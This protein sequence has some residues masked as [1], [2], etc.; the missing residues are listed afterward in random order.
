MSLS[1]HI[2]TDNLDPTKRN[3]ALLFVG[4]TQ[5]AY[6]VI[7]GGAAFDVT[8]QA[9]EQARAISPATHIIVRKLE[10][11]GIWVKL[12]PE[13]WFNDRVAPYLAWCQKNEVVYLTDNESSGDDDTIRR[14]AAWQADVMARLH[15]VGLRAAVCAFS[16]GNI[17]ENQYALLKPVYDAMIPGDV[18]A[19]HEYQ[20]A[21]HKSS[22][23]HVNRYQLAWQA[24]GR[25]LPTVITEAGIAVDYNPGLGYHSLGMSAADYVKYMAGFDKDWYAPHNVTIC[26]Y[27]T[28]GYG[29][30]SFQISDDV[31]T[32]LEKL[33]AS[34]PVPTP[35][36]PPPPPSGDFDYGEMRPAHIRI[37]NPTITTINMRREPNIV[38][39]IWQ[40]V[41]SGDA[42]DWSLTER[43]IGGYNWHKVL[44]KTSG[45][46]G[47][48]AA[49]SSFEV[50][51][52]APPQPPSP[53]YTKI[54]ISK[55]N[56]AQ[57][58]IAEALTLLR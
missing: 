51:F 24:A 5:P 20:N 6:A 32:E 7:G 3:R 23:G 1:C 21:P 16:T 52:D 41:T 15:A 35:A 42:I 44:H 2:I 36:P 48:I 58:L 45:K 54:A 37:T 29:W 55:L 30:E 10:D 47:Y 27:V 18:W 25:A 26:L 56:D 33:P 46:M 43:A 22:G 28:G 31:F 14:Y 53:D 12:N 8:M 34:I 4:R 39:S 50:D 11:T 17:G 13:Q 40:L 49:T 57:Q 9:V 38:A 19:S